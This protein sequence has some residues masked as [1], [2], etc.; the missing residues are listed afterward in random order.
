MFL[1]KM[2][3]FKPKM[4]IS[5]IAQ[6][7]T[8]IFQKIGGITPEAQNWGGVRDPSPRSA[9]VYH[10]TFSELTRPL[11]SSMVTNS[12]QYMFR[13][14]LKHLIILHTIIIIIIIINNS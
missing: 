4:H 6:I 11:I 5:Q 12:D 10:L 14:R 2:R 9:R 13:I 3:I 8:Y 1:F 7:C